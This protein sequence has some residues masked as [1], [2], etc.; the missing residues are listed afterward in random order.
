MCVWACVCVCGV[1]ASVCVGASVCECLLKCFCKC[2]CARV[3]GCV[4]G[5]V[6]MRVYICVCVCLCACV[7][8]RV[9]PGGREKLLKQQLSWGGVKRMGGGS[10]LAARDNNHRR[11]ITTLIFVGPR[12]MVWWGYGSSEGPHITRGL[13]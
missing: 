7:C 6:C 2:V 10:P 4:F 3:C 11:E 13:R 5:C 8:V 1:F 9:H 12:G